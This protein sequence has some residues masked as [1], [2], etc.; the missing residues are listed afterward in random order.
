MRLA[1]VHVPIHVVPSLKPANLRLTG[2]LADGWIGNS[3]LCEHASVFFDEIAEGA[4]LSGR[5]L[6]DLD[7][8]VAVSCELSDD[9]DEAGRRHADGYAFTFGAMG[10]ARTNF[11][12][13][14]FE[15]QGFGDAVAEVQRLWLAGDHAAAR[16]AVPVEIGLRTNLIGPPDEVRRRLREYRDCGVD[17]LRVNPIGDSLRRPPGRLARWLADWSARSTTQLRAGQILMTQALRRIALQA[18]WGLALS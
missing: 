9:V 12:N 8:T 16:R 4:A 15:R 7:L 10:S 13:R 17:T 3:F 1:G 6:A 5:S 14:A 2:E 18:S 11:Y